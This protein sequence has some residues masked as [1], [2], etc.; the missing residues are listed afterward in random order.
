VTPANR[1]FAQKG[2]TQLPNLGSKPNDQLPVPR[3]EHRQ[4]EKSHSITGTYQLYDLLD[5]STT[6][7]TISI[8]VEVQP[9]DKP[10]VLR[11]STTSGSVNVR[12][13]PTSGEGGWFFWKKPKDTTNLE[14]KVQNLGRV[15]QTEISTKSGS[16]SGSVV[17]GNGGST[18]ISTGSGSISIS[19]Y[20][21]GVSGNDP[22]STLT[23]SAGS[24][25]QNIRILSPSSVPGYRTTTSAIRALKVAHTTTGSG[26]ISAI[27]PDE[28]EGQLHIV[29]RGS[30]SINA[31]G[32]GLQLQRQGRRELFGL[33]GEDAET[34]ASVEITEMG[35]GSVNFHC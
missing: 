6:S 35:S 29:T 32:D 30:G 7:G 12:M 34:G 16:A 23:T 2:Q 27:Y 25:S 26:S 9:G 1:I 22:L 24:G 31:G 4:R 3:R 18:T 14:E 15:F 28:W 8:T 17:H 33:K 10:A 11:L 20:P 19:V 5:L 21:V 13:V